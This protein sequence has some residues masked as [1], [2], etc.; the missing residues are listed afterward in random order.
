MLHHGTL[1]IGVPYSPLESE[2]IGVVP[3]LSLCCRISCA[4]SE[5]EVPVVVSPHPF[6]HTPQQ[7]C[8]ASLTGPGVLPHTI[9]CGIPLLS[10]IV[11]SEKLT[12]SPRISIQPLPT[13]LRLWCPGSG[14]DCLWGFLSAFP[15]SDQL[16]HFSSRL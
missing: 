14:T 13:C 2:M 4:C 1:S 10:P 8:L 6:P 12:Q 16:R 9:G 15:S 3:F 5:K 7:W 11:L